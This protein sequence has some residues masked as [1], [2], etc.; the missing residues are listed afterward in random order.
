[1]LGLLPEVL[2]QIALQSISE[3][4]LLKSLP[5]LKVDLVEFLGVIL[6]EISHEVFIDNLISDVGWLQLLKFKFDGVHVEDA[7]AGLDH[8]GAIEAEN[9]WGSHTLNDLIVAHIFD[10]LH[11]LDHLLLLYVLKILLSVLGRLKRIFI[12][13]LFVF[14]LDWVLRLQDLL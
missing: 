5:S 3:A 2:G 12:I 10:L 6:S 8:R 11:L 13:L 7:L 9:I 4:I 14:H 1:M